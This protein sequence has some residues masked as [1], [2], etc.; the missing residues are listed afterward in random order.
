MIKILRKSLPCKALITIYK[1]IIR[2]HVDNGDI[3]YDQ[4]S[5]ATSCQKIKAFQYKAAFAITDAIQST[6]QEKL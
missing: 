5:N 1:A 4:T 2:P 3:L 6:S